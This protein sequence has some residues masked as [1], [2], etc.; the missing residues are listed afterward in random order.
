MDEGS[1]LLGRAFRDNPLTHAVVGGRD[2][3][4]LR[5]TRRGMALQMRQ[6]LEHG[7]V[8][9]AHAAGRLAGGGL[10]LRVGAG[11]GCLPIERRC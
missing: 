6:F 4:R 9:G 1:A 11:P 2:A 8:V 5:S 7:E 3:T 10:D